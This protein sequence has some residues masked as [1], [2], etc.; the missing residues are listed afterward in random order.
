MVRGRRGGGRKGRGGEEWARSYILKGCW[1]NFNRCRRSTCPQTFPSASSRPFRFF[2]LPSAPFPVI[3]RKKNMHP[4]AG[5]V[6]CRL[7]KHAQKRGLF[8]HFTQISTG[9]RGEISRRTTSAR[10]TRPPELQQPTENAVGPMPTPD[11]V[12]K[13][14]PVCPKLDGP[15]PAK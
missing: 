10:K 7:V 1:N 3:W 9:R 13:R 5:S 4:P 12:I 2:L 14:Q 8:G 15:D 11:P 6:S